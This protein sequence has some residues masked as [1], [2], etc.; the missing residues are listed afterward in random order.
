M[1]LKS[2]FLKKNIPILITLVDFY[3]PRFLKWIRIRPNDTDPTGYGPG[4]E[5]RIE[6]ASFTLA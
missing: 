5:T 1:K 2:L 6:T 3:D 4:S